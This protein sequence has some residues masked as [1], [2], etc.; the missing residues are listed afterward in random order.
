MRIKKRYLIPLLLIIVFL[1]G[2]RLKFPKFDG[3]LPKMEQNIHSIENFVIETEKAVQNLKPNNEARI[4]WADSIPKKTE[5]SVVY[6]HGYSASPMEGDG[7]HTQFAERYGANLYLARLAGH[8]IKTKD[9]FLDVTSKDWIES[10]KEA[11]AIGQ[12][13]GEKVIVLSAS[14]GSTLGN[15]IAAENPDAIYAHF[16]Y[17]PNFKMADQSAQILTWPWG[18]QIARKVMGSKYRIG[19]FNER[20]SVYWTFKQRLEGVGALVHLVNKTTGVKKYKKISHP[21]FIAY[22]YKNEEEKDGAVSIPEM[23]KYHENTSTPS[24]KKKF[25][26][27]PDCGDHCMVSTLRSKDL[28][29]IRTET[30]KFAEEVLG[31]EAVQ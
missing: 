11:I 9:A 24:K 20:D 17:S 15:Y 16:M 22:Y 18:L 10:A 29:G 21:H 3:K 13:L 30:Y 23:K 5:Y 1:I 6:L 4:I 27:F 14:T 25:I 31:M 28:E 8:G 19:K 2:P 12:I 26:A 7:I